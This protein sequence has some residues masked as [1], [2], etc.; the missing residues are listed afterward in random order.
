MKSLNYKDNLRLNHL[1]KICAGGIAAFLLWTFAYT[2][3][4]V[5]DP[6]CYTTYLARKDTSTPRSLE[7]TILSHAP[8][9]TTIEGA[10]WRNHTWI[11]VTSK[12][13]SFPPMQHVVTN[14]PWHNAEIRWDESVARVVTPREAREMALDVGRAVNVEGSSVSLSL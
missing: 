8:G 6:G 14:A 1:F 5:N 13:W 9:F 12:P 2:P 3:C 10:Y 7:T 11:F 4:S